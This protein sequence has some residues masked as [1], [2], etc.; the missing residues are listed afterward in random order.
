MNAL[1]RRITL[2]I[3]QPTPDPGPFIDLY[4][5]IGG[6]LFWG[7]IV[8]IFVGVLTGCAL[9]MWEKLDP[10]REEKAGKAIIFGIGGAMLAGMAAGVVNWAAG[11]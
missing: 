3:E 8:A 7:V 1:T 6:L 9:F 4:N 11:T 2:S 10:T 5:R